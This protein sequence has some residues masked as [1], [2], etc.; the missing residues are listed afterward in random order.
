M[1]VLTPLPG[2]GQAVFDRTVA[3]TKADGSKE[4]WLDVAER[5]AYGNLLLDRRQ[6]RGSVLAEYVEMR[7]AIASGTLLMSGRH[8][9]H[10]DSEQHHKPAELHTNCLRYSTLVPTIEYGV[11]QLGDLVGKRVTIRARDGI[12]REAIVRS[13][14]RQQINKISFSAT[15]GSVSKSAPLEVFATPNHRWFLEDGTT[16]SR[17]QVGDVI[18]EVPSP[19]SV[20]NE[21]VVHGLVFGDG[22]SHK[23]RQ[24]ADYPLASQGRSY[25][26]IRLCGQRKREY[27]QYFD[28]YTVKYPP[29]AEGDPVV[30]VGR[31]NYKDLPFTT[32]PEYIAGF[33]H[34]WW[35][36]DGRKNERN[37]TTIYSTRKDAVDWLVAHCAYAGYVCVSLRVMERKPGDGSYANG[38]PLYVVR[39]SKNAKRRVRSIEYVGEEDVYCVT[40]PVTG[41]FVLANGLLTGNCSTAAASFMSL[42][43]LLSGCGVGRSYDDAM[44]T[45][46]WNFMPNLTCVLSRAHPDYT[47]VFPTL[48]EVGGAEDKIYVR[49]EDSREGWARS[50]EIL[51]GLTFERNFANEHL[52]LDFSDVRPKDAPIRGMQNRP[53]S[54]PVPLMYAFLEAKKVKGK[55]MHAW[56][57]NMRIDHAFA[58]CVAVGGVRRAARIAIKHWRDN[59]ILEFIDIKTHGGLWSANNSVGVDAEFWEDVKREDSWAQRVFNATTYAAYEHGTGEPGFLNID[60]LNFVRGQDGFTDGDYVGNERYEVTKPGKRVLAA[61]AAAARKLKYPVIVNPCSEISLSVLGGYCTLAS[62]APYFADTL[63]QATRAFELAARAL[64]RVNLMPALYHREVARTNRI[65]VGF[66]GIFEFAWKFWQLSFRDLIADYDMLMS[67]GP[68]GARAYPFWE[69]MASARVATEAAADELSDALGVVRPHSVTMV[70]PTGTISKVFGLTEGAHLPAFREYLRW[71]QFQHGDPLIE[72]YRAK[73]YLVMD[74]VPAG[75]SD[76]YR[77]VSLVGFPTRM[78][79]RT[80]GIPDEQFVTASEAT[81]EEQFQWLT[82]LEKY[83][84]GP[85]GNQV[86]YTMKYVR[87]QLSYQHYVALV[88]KW[89]PKVRCVSVLPTD[90][91]ETTVEKY[92]YAPEEPITAD[93]YARIESNIQRATEVVTHDE[94]QCASGAC[95]I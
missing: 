37:A 46:N 60:R 27:L 64:V 78:L 24:N 84:L 58:A 85:R 1:T 83:W 67:N 92:G 52:V 18:G 74:D 88:S 90:A 51:E 69:W 28:N 44:M 79:I 57:Q 89:M 87:G 2:M 93:A 34:G 25:C 63:E 38:K 71:V 68:E 80:L 56:E 47:G 21:A 54:G 19:N 72:E 75:T 29:H 3:R 42:M 49:V 65:G 4:S 11:A 31:K 36:A 43:L 8:Q 30:Y 10:G 22:G 86:S 55:H 95:P 94:L 26:S 13:F 45:V 39:L 35:L 7:N 23:A 20:D 77:D 61:A 50:L 6:A 62:C 32:D 53:A 12:W 14:G 16:T 5:M 70:A 15:N 82:L 73:G 48:E 41:G 81:M 76:S 33:I 91:W 9:Q 66:T 59:D 40:E 17:L